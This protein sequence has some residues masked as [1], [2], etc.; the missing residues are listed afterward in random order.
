MAQKPKPSAAFA[1]PPPLHCSNFGER[2]LSLRRTS[3]P[4]DYRS[5]AGSSLRGP[6]GHGGGFG[7]RAPPESEEEQA[8]RVRSNAS[9]LRGSYRGRR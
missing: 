7:A 5:M 1:P 6:G 2:F 3:P 9:R 8:T 4:P